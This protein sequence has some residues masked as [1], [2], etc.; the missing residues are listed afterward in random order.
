MI[1][2]GSRGSG[3]RIRRAAAAGA[4]VLTLF[5][6]ATTAAAPSASAASS[7]S[8]TAATPLPPARVAG[9][10]N[11]HWAAQ[12]GGAPSTSC[13][14]SPAGGT[15]APNP[16]F[17]GSP[18]LSYHN[19]PVV[20]GST[21]GRLTVTPVYWVP[22]TGGFAIPAAYESLLDNYVADVAAD[23]GK[24]SNV[25]ASAAQYTTTNGA[26]GHLR[27]DIISGAPI[28][29]TN[30]LPTGGCSPDSGAVYSDSTPYRACITS[31]QLLSEASS[32]VSAQSLPSDLS[33]LYVYFLPKGV[34]TCFTT[35]NGS[36]GGTCS[37]NSATTSGFCAY[38]AFA[39][40]PLVADMNFPV[41]DDPVNHLTCSSDGGSN[42]GGNQTP[43]NNLDADT[44]IS[45]ASHEINET[46]S[47]PKGTAWFDAGGNEIGDDCAYIYGNSTGF[48]GTAGHFFN[49]TVN[50]P[51]YFTQFELSNEDYATPTTHANACVGSA[52]TPTAAFSVT[53][54]SPTVNAPVAF[55][56]TTS[57]NPADLTSG[58][59]TYQWQWG[60]ATADGSGATPTHTYTTAATFTVT[61]TVT[62]VD[63]WTATVSHPLSVTLAPPAVSASPTPINRGMP[64]TVTWSGVSHPS[65]QNFVALYPSHSTPAGSS[66]ASQ[67]TSGASSGTLTLTVP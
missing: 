42:T 34:E 8:C 16:P 56:G 25:F 2:D 39:A 9:E 47:D 14:A 5:A 63:G 3:L 20:G 41:E 13:P 54:T 44:E 10:A 29:D 60:D 32:L 67:P 37:V 26:S 15:T 38:H 62:D 50:G 7:P 55:D 33:H 27:Y 24:P 66:V 45:I 59:L 18:P 43:N 17:R 65:T 40:P 11:V 51:Q 52:Q 30:P 28:T 46:M 57:H 1:A 35:A 48:G 12:A 36:A 31:A 53:T 58:A 49:Q 64:L 19:G 21:P 6:A 61:L 22:T 4:G 23:S